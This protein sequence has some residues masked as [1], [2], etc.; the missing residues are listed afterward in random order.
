MQTASCGPDYKALARSL[1][2]SRGNRLQLVDAKNA[3]DLRQQPPEQ[4][5]ITAVMRMK[6]G[7]L[8]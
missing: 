7:W 3:F 6:Y 2:D 1:D 8:V 4:A 5:E